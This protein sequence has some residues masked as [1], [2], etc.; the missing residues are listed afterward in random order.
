MNQRVWDLDTRFYTNAATMTPPL[1]PPPGQRKENTKSGQY[2]QLRGFSMAI[3]SPNEGEGGDTGKPRNKDR[4]R[5]YNNV[6]HDSERSRQ[7]HVHPVKNIRGQ[8]R[9]AS[10]RGSRHLQPRVLSMVINIPNVATKAESNSH[11]VNTF[12]LFWEHL[13]FDCMGQAHTLRG[14]LWSRQEASVATRTLGPG[15][16]LYGW[17]CLDQDIT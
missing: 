4:V 13:D 3:N 6:H 7:A 16:M 1:S 14:R 17:P 12:S 11:L 8:R 2:P 15:L 5:Y 9:V 10:T